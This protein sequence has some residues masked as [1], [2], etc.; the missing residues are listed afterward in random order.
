MT[1]D[2]IENGCSICFVG[3]VAVR[4]AEFVI[5]RIGQGRRLKP[6]R[7]AVATSLLRVL[8]SQ[9]RKL[10]IRSSMRQLFGLAASLMLVVCVDIRAQ[11]PPQPTPNVPRNASGQPDLAAPAPRALD[12]HPDLSGMWEYVRREG[13]PLPR[14]GPLGQPLAGTSQFW[15]V[16]TG[17]SEP[18]PFTAWGKEA[19][20]QRIAD[21]SRGNPD[22]HCLPLGIMQLHTHPN[23]RRFVQTPG[24]IVMLWEANGSI[25]QIFTDGRPLPDN[26]P[27]PWYHGYS[28]GRWE[29]DTLVV[30]T[31]GFRDDGW[32]DVSGTPLTS[33]AKTIERFHRLNFGTL[34]IAVTVEDSKAY[35]KPW[36]VSV[37]NRIMLDTD[38]ME[39]VCQENEK[40]SHLF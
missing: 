34:D 26:D 24:L 14:N 25:R 20:T 31:T 12:G 11:W 17:M 37:R 7:R 6:P 38:L 18:L 1:Q 35:T 22:A 28:V 8:K 40:S 16:S 29:G 15:D 4:P 32:L 2:D 30:D 27:Q 10:T 36:T 33:A 21:N 5:F 23:P 19:L 3:V 9:T 39:F 13:L